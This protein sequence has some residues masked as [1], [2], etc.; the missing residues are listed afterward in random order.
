MR[1]TTKTMVL[2]SYLTVQCS[3]LSP[4]GIIP[5]QP[6]I[7]SVHR[8]AVQV[9]AE[10]VGA[11]ERLFRGRRCAHSLIRAVALPTRLAYDSP[12]PVPR[13]SL[14]R[15]THTSSLV[16]LSL[17]FD[18]SKKAFLAILT[19]QSSI[20]THTTSPQSLAQ[21]PLY[22]WDTRSPG[23]QLLYIR[24][25]ETANRELS[26]PFIGPLGFDLEWKPTYRK[27]EAENP[28]ALVQL[29]SA[30]RILLLQISAMRSMSFSHP[31]RLFC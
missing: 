2:T 28:V 12:V 22:Q 14:R 27:G 26:R 19:M 23:T 6:S 13:Y 9:S 1:V 25:V 5:P 15:S 11:L 18:E 20:A 29:A 30:D 3:F 16:D 7:H 21:L 4:F 31:R 10:P 24:D 17:A 8:F